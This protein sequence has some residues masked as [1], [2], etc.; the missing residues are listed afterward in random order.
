MQKLYW[1]CG[2]DGI[3]QFL[4]IS[5]ECIWYQFYHPYISKGWWYRD[6]IGIKNTC[7]NAALCNSTPSTTRS[8]PLVKAR[9]KP[10]SLLDVAP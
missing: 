3:M 8:D 10:W 9:S 7:F 5:E 4:Q 6:S 1:K 2:I